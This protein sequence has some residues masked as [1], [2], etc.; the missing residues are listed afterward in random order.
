MN[1]TQIAHVLHLCSLDWLLRCVTFPQELGA[2]RVTAES[3]FL[4][5]AFINWHDIHID[6]STLLQ[7]AA[8]IY[9]SRSDARWQKYLSRRGD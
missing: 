3:V 2:T 9:I 1:V 6:I 5:T 8:Y 7:V 4:P